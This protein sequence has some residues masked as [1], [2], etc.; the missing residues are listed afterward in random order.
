MEKDKVI[1]AHCRNFILMVR[2]LGHTAV[3]NYLHSPYLEFL[4]VC[5]LNCLTSNGCHQ[6]KCGFVHKKHECIQEPVIK[7]LLKCKT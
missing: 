3:S 5:N 6:E 1:T 7:I 4:L 2:P